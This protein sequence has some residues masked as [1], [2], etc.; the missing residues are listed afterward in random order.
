MM[1]NKLKS[2]MINDEG[3]AFDPRTGNTYT[4]NA[5]GL[6]IVN[7]LKTGASS[8]QIVKRLAE[9]FEVDEQTADR[10]LEAF[11]TALQRQRLI[12]QEVAS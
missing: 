5:T 1:T 4:M 12:D 11:L 10:D 9:Q 3:F 6:L 8:G 7:S 2:L